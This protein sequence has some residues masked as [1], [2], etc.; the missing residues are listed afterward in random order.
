MRR[1]RKRQATG[2]VRVSLDLIPAGITAL[3]TAGFLPATDR[4]VANA[5]QKAFVRAAVAGGLAAD[6]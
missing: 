5:V 2:V 6:N 1:S 4:A 3:N